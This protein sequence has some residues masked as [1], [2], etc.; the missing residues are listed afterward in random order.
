MKY[1]H[2][3]EGKGGL[4]VTFLFTLF[5]MCSSCKK[6]DFNNKSKKNN[7]KITTE[8]VI[9]KFHLIRDTTIKKAHSSRNFDRMYQRNSTVSPKYTWEDVTKKY[10]FPTTLYFLNA[11]EANDFLE[12]IDNDPN[13]E[14][15]YFY[16]HQ[17]FFERQLYENGIIDDTTSNSIKYTYKECSGC[18]VNSEIHPMGSQT[19]GFCQ[20]YIGPFTKICVE[21]DED[22][23]EQEFIGIGSAASGW[24]LGFGFL[25]MGGD[26]YF[27]EPSL[28]SFHITF[29]ISLSLFWG[30]IGTFYNMEPETHNGQYDVD[31]HA[32]SI[33]E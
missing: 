11:Q 24:Q 28:I 13:M 23:V 5:A 3:L 18:K 17:D 6:T 1:R 26:G 32:G 30:G 19:V 22:P 21:I 27:S 4:L 16:T 8:E 14:S 10:D 9:Q 7:G 20:N 29:Q 12:Y 31:S 25:D 15:Y 2:L 33:F